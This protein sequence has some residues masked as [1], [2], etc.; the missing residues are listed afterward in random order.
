[1]D[2][3]YPLLPRNVELDPFFT[4]KYYDGQDE[5]V[6]SYEMP[7]SCLSKTTADKNGKIKELDLVESD[8]CTDLSDSKNTTSLVVGK[9]NQRN[10][11][12]KDGATKCSIRLK[13]AIGSSSGEH[14]PPAQIYSFRSSRS[15]LEEGR[16]FTYYEVKI[17]NMFPFSQIYMGFALMPSFV[18]NKTPGSYSGY[19]Y[20][21]KAS[22]SNHNNQHVFLCRSYGLNVCSKSF[23]GLDRYGMVVEGVWPNIEADAVIGCGYDRLLNRIFYTHNRKI[24][25]TLITFSCPA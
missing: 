18:W 19:T 13:I 12:F 10:F 6:H 11:E 17:D 21:S 24:F 3:L 1:M 25:G 4:S 23:L 15:L 5:L 2:F 16:R 14:Q 22:L 8:V 7:F 9:A 20:A